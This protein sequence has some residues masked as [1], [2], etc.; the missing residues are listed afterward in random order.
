MID[1]EGKI[2]DSDQSKCEM[3]NSYF[4]NVYTLENLSNIPSTTTTVPTVLMSCDITLEK[5]KSLL[6]KLNISKAAGPDNLHSKILFELRE[7]I[8]TPLFMIFNK[9]LYE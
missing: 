9:S 2:H 5:V 7:V 6:T 8:S 1:L 3:F 4:A